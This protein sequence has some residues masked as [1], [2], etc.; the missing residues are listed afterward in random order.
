[1]NHFLPPA[2]V[3]LAVIMFETTPPETRVREMR[4]FLSGRLEA[5]HYVRLSQQGR[6]DLRAI[7]WGLDALCD[8]LAPQPPVARSRAGWWSRALGWVR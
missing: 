8:Q 3:S 2:A 4:R 5:G 1:M 6:E 7:L